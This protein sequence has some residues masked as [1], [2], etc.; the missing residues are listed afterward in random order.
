MLARMSLENELDISEI[1]FGGALKVALA[2]KVF[3]AL[4]A[5]AAV[6]SLIS[7]L[8]AET[9]IEQD[10]SFYLAGSSVVAAAIFAAGGSALEILVEIYAEVWRLRVYTED[11]DD[12]L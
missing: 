9:A 6:L 10:L 4:L 1:R 3:A 11:E 2:L 12:D 5:V 8:V 7:G